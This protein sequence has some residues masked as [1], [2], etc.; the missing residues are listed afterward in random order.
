VSEGAGENLFMVRDGVIHTPGGAHSILGGITRDTVIRR[1]RDR[2]HAGGALHRP[3]PRPRGHLAAGLHRAA[4]AR[5]EGAAP[6]R[7]LAT[8]DH[9]TPTTPQGPDGDA[10][11]DE[12]AAAQQ[13]ASSSQ[14]RAS[15]AS[16]CSAGSQRAAASCT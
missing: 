14:L 6:D 12:Q 1:P 10:D 2:R 8:M 7:T 11:R 13:V 16:S 4:R 9:S 5:P 3:A 15:S